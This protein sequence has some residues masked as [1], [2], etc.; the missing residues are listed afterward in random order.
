MGVFTDGK[1]YTLYGTSAANFILMPSNYDIGYQAK[2][3]QVVANNVYGLT[4][5]GL[6]SLVT[7]L[8]YGDF[9]FAAL[10]F[11]IQ[12]L[13]N[14]K[15]GTATASVALRTKNQYRIFF[16]DGTALVIGLTGEKI[17]GIM[18]L[19]YGKTVYCTVTAALSTGE[20]VTY[21]GSDDG[22][23]YQDN[24][25][26][27]FDGAEIEAWLRPAFN[28]LKSPRV[29]K[30]Y[31]RAIFEV[32][33]EGFSMVNISYDIGYANPD[34]QPSAVQ[35][36]K[37]LTGAGGYWDQFTWDQFSWDSQIVTNADLSLDGSENNIAFLFYSKRAQDD[38]HVV[39][40]VNLLY[41][42]RRLVH[43]GS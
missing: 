42:P 35:Q 37:L 23:V 32:E 38:S 1:H 28:N 3:I 30:Q 25:G 16:A 20:E 2:T 34:T 9:E 4:A 33:C 15:M 29:R 18:P 27:S 5:R 26:T 40:G 12:P 10:S 21:F 7:T 39:Q 43:S 11:F 13:I 41:T 22:Y 31:R 24:V 19:N 8:N 17:A 6:Q 36:D 14:R